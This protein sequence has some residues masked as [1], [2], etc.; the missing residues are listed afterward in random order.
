MAVS[1]PVAIVTGGA[2]G[3]GEATARALG[4]RGCRTV[5][6]DL[7]EEAARETAGRLQ[8]DGLPVEATAVDVTDPGSV[9]AMV[10]GISS[11]LGRIDVLVNNAGVE[12]PRPFLDL[13][14]D[15]YERVMRINTT[16][17]WICC[18]AVIPV[19]LR[20][21]SGSIVNL[22][23]VAGQRGGG[24]LGTAAYST[25]KG[26]V[27]ALTK[28]LA[29]EFAKSGIRVNA[30]SPSLTMTALA[31]RQLQRLPEGTMERVVAMTPMGRPAQPHEVASVVAF[32]ASEEASFVT[33]HVYNVDGGSAM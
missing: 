32:L 9:A 10:N 2:G 5:I 22:S 13:T 23:S 14:L 12:S 24:L 16:S 28:A 26:A 8:S 6:A 27:I 31:E 15:D 1:E 19:M 17:V 33:G 21:G 11:R 25:S 7:R 18:Q 4:A 20:Q 30:V 29:R 3:I